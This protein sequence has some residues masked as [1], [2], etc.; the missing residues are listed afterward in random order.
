MNVGRVRRTL[1]ALRE[2]PGAAAARR[3][4]SR[5]PVAIVA[6][7]ILISGLGGLPL[8]RGAGERLP[9]R[10]SDREFWKIVSDSSEPDGYFRSDNLLSN[11]LGFPYVVPTLVKSAKQGGVYL[12]VGPEQNFNYIAALKPKMVFIVDVRRGNF[13]LQ[14][15]YKALFELSDNRVEFVSRLFSKKRPQHL[16]TQSTPQEIFAAYAGVEHDFGAY[17]ENLQA[18]D[19]QLTMKHHFALS[20]DDLK[21]IEYVYKAFYTYGP[22]I[23]YS[24]TQGG[25]G[26]FRQP[27]YADLMQSA[28][29]R[30][31]THSYLSTEENFTILK[32]LERKNLLVPVVGNFGGP[33]AIRAVGEYLKDHGATVSAF[34][35]SNVEQYLWRDGIWSRFCDNVAALPLDEAS[36]FIR[37]VRGGRY[38]PGYRQGFGLDLDLV[39]IAPEVKDCHARQ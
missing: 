34:Y 35:L 2:A 31:N 27:S 24:S 26:G 36:T 28:D 11:E 29:D 25:Y 21:G 22:E 14:M 1:S 37:A 10:L 23:R 16:S 7:L 9:D 39:P 12:G 13:D 6:V 4:L 30:G 32:D 3:F 33:K 38:G 20:A 5:R 15:M 19:N 8:V 18:I 17:T